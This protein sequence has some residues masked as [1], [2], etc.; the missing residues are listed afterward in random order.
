MRNTY[1]FLWFLGLSIL[2][3]SNSKPQQLSVK[4]IQQAPANSGRSFYTENISQ[5]LLSNVL[6]EPILMKKSDARRGYRDD[7]PTV[8]VNLYYEALC[9]YCTDWVD[10]QLVPTH[11][12]LGKYINFGLFPYGNTIDDGIGQQ[13]KMTSFY[14]K[15]YIPSV[16]TV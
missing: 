15:S 16:L 12:K 11:Q 6:K 2:K 9:P 13:G 14:I 3:L 8:D 10:N 5:T 4:N 1:L 7:V